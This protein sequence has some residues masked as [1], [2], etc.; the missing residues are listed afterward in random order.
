MVEAIPGVNFRGLM[1]V[2]HEHASRFDLAPF[3]VAELGERA[4][5]PLDLSQ[6]LQHDL[7]L[8]L[9]EAFL[10]ALV[11]QFPSGGYRNADAVQAEYEFLFDPWD[12][13]TRAS[14]PELLQPRDLIHGPERTRVVVGDDAAVR[15]HYDPPEAGDTRGIRGCEF[16]E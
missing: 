13:T 4:R 7:R 8:A 14:C 15:R 11:E 6:V 2:E 9:A 3:V 16:L 12:L 1:A 5:F 10:C